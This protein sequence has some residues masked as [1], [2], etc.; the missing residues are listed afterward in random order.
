M[1]SPATQVH[2]V[3]CNIEHTG[4]APVTSYFLPQDA[5]SC[6]LGA[7]A[8][9]HQEKYLRLCTEFLTGLIVDGLSIREAAFRGR[10]LKGEEK[11]EQAYSKTCRF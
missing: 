10:R 11:A 9:R 2:H 4:S 6:C 3:P 8:Q 7:S 1:G 5:G